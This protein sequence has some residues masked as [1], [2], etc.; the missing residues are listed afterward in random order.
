MFCTAAGM[1][2]RVKMNQ[3]IGKGVANG[4]TGKIFHIDWRSD[5][6]FERKNDG[7]W[8]ASTAP[9]NVVVDIRDQHSQSRFPGNPAAWPAS[10]MPVLQTR[11]KFSLASDSI[12]IKGYPVVPAFGTTVHG[13][14][15]DTRDK[16]VVTDLRP[17]HFHRI[18]RHTLY[19]ALSR[20][21]TRAGLYWAGRRLDNS[22]FVYFCPN[23]EGLAEDQRL[24][25]LAATTT[26]RTIACCD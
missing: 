13:V 4:A 18:D 3:C 17:P 14:Q 16:I 15:G 7:V 1:L 23:E 25:N 11:A 9:S 12:S 24:H 21:R 19:V 2:V 10:V 6:Q 20:V 5:T 22:D 26:A 8:V